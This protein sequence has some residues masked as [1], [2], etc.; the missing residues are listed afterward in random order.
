[1]SDSYFKI[2]DRYFVR[3]QFTLEKKFV[4]KDFFLYLKKKRNLNLTSIEKQLKL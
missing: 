2:L 4:I 1:M 3:A